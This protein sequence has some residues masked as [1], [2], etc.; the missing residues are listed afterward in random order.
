MACA[1]AASIEENPMA[2]VVALAI[3]VLVIIPIGLYYFSARLVRS[4]KR[5]PR[6]IGL[7]IDPG[8]ENDKPRG[9][10]DTQ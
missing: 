1:R 6:W 2:G 4:T 8:T 10:T 5:P 7:P 9:D 3:F